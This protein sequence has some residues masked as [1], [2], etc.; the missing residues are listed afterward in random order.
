MAKEEYYSRPEINYKK[1]TF[2][3]FDFLM[4]AV[5]AAIILLVLPIDFSVGV[6][7]TTAVRQ[8]EI[9][10][11]LDEDTLPAGYIENLFRTS[12]SNRK[13]QNGVDKESY[14]RTDFPWGKGYI[15]GELPMMRPAPACWFV[16]GV[17]F[18]VD[19][20]RIYY[21]YNGYSG[22]VEDPQVGS[23]YCRDGKLDYQLVLH[24]LAKDSTGTV[25]LR[26]AAGLMHLVNSGV[27]VGFSG[28][29]AW[30]RTEQVDG[31]SEVIG[32]AMN[33]NRV[34]EPQTISQADVGVYVIADTYLL[35]D[36]DGKIH[37]RNML[38]GDVGNIVLDG[39][40]SGLEYAINESGEIYV[41]FITQDKPAYGTFKLTGE[42]IKYVNGTLDSLES[43]P[44]TIQAHIYHDTIYCTVYCEEGNVTFR[45]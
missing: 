7:G 18:G 25:T 42:G 26:E 43:A 21:Y 13:L 20:E 31:Q 17:Q 33:G 28:D 39:R 4:I 30:F 14:T 9:N 23:M 6:D 22:W 45:R 15:N 41:L 27:L 1:R 36:A 40:L 44:I 37:I 19:A 11:R 3:L 16:N 8:E 29:T 35:K 5:M 34:G 38:T 2:F 24:V 32:Y 10:R 12:A